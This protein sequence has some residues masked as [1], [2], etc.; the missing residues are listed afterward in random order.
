MAVNQYATDNNQNSDSRWSLLSPAAE[1]QLQQR[2]ANSSSSSSS[3]LHCS[4]PQLL[5]LAQPVL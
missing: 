2:L 1:S 4:F 5:Q 3:G